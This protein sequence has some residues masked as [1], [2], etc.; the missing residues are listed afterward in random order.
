MKNVTNQL[1]FY[2][3]KN[4]ANILKGLQVFIYINYFIFYIFIY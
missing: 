1:Y 4:F 3:V 2:F